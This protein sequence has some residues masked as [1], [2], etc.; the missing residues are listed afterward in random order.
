MA[1]I[2][3]K[4]EAWKNKLLDLGKRNRL[5]N[6]RDTKRSSL[7]IKEPIIFELWESFVVNETPLEFPYY[8]DEQISLFENNENEV[9][10][11]SV[12]TN[13]SIKEQQ[14]SLRSLREKAKT[15]MEEQ[16]VNILYLSFGFLRWREDTKSDQYFL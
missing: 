7:R 14:K 16:G 9:F 15:A 1:T 6:Y 4:L 5:I 3:Q 8:D 2:D 10:E 13:Q 11:E 12:L